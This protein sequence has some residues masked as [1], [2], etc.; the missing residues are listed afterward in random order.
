MDTLFQDEALGSLA[1]QGSLSSLP[2]SCL[3][4]AETKDHRGKELDLFSVGVIRLA[5]GSE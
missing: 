1:G 3:G 5:V 4:P 2:Q